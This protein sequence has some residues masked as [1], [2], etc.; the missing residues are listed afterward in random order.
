[1]MTSGVYNN[2]PTKIDIYAAISWDRRSRY[3][4]ETLNR[5]EHF[6]IQDVSTL[7]EAEESSSISRLTYY[8]I[9]SIILI[10][11]FLPY[12]ISNSTQTINNL[13][14]YSLMM[15]RNN[16]ELRREKRKAEKLLNEML[17]RSVAERL[18]RGHDVMAES[19]EAVTV[20][21]SDIPDF[22]D[23]SQNSSPM[24]IVSFLNEVRA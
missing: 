20:Y 14:M 21:F 4:I 23:I 19:F 13:R 22:S 18:R 12:F 16:L 6:I 3:Q 9:I 2:L 8:V 15:T 1:M 11:T 10:S 17:P 5:V 24:E 7:L